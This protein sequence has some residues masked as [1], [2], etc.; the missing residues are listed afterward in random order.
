MITSHPEPTSHETFR[1][2]SQDFFKSYP[3]YVLVNSQE[4][5]N[6]VL[7]AGCEAEYLLVL[8]ADSPPGVK[9]FKSDEIKEFRGRIG[10]IIHVLPFDEDL[11]IVA[12]RLLE[13]LAIDGT[14][15]GFATPEQSIQW[16]QACFK[17]AKAQKTVDAQGQE[18]D[19]LTLEWS[20]K[21][22]KGEEWV[23]WT[24]IKKAPEWAFC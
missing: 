15:I 5:A 22:V 20:A 19:G 9:S 1:P 24:V 3:P 7:S 13:L 16:N 4:D 18:Q 2:L 8:D 12:S 10:I 6:A 23:Q 11:S 21:D 14:A 17:W